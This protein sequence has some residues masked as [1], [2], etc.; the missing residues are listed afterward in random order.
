MSG[1]NE[2]RRKALGINKNAQRE[3]DRL[4]RQRVLEEYAKRNEA[5][6]ELEPNNRGR[7]AI[8]SAAILAVW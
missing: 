5:S 4:E 6:K 8:A 7:A 3:I 2:A 1:K